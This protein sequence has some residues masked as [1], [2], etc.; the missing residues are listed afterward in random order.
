MTGATPSRGGSVG[1][2]PA[3][4]FATTA[5]VALVVFSLGMLSLLLDED[6]IA[7]PGIGPIP[8]I[9]ATAAAALT[10]SG[11]LWSAIRSRPAGEG[12]GE[13]AGTGP[14]TAS[15]S[16]GRRHPSFW[17]A[18]W[19]ALAAALAYV[20][21]LGLAAVVT[22]A[23]LAAAAAIAG[24]IA[25]SWFGAAILLAALVCAWGGVALVRTRAGRPRWP[26]EQDDDT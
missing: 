16:A 21:V 19:I 23:D 4:A 24:R 5:F 1:P 17:N 10:F 22:G 20:V 11:C 26:W 2:L 9:A 18:P 8:G 13:G 25:T 7:V 12:P 3:L 6:V 15:A 14:S